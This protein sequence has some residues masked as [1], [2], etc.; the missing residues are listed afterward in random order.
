MKELSAFF[1]FI[2]AIFAVILSWSINKSVFWAILHFLFGW[3]YVI[4]FYL[5][6]GTLKPIHDFLHQLFGNLI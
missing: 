4:Y 3:L 5:A 6:Y 2:G 1:E